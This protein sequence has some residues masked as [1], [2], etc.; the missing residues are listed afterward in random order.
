MNFQT[1]RTTFKDYPIFSKKEIEKTLSPFD[2]KNLVN[3]QK[4]NYVQKVRNEWY[5]L[6]ENHL[7]TPT[8]Y[9]IS[10]HIY[11]PSYISVESALAHYGFI[12]EGVFRHTAITTLKTQNFDTPIG[13]FTYQTLKPNLFFGYNLLNFNGFNYK[14]ADP[15][16]CILDFLYLNP[17]LKTEGHFYELRLNISD[18]KAQVDFDL[19]HKYAVAFDAQALMQRATAFVHFVE[20]S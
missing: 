13:L 17:H 15:Q 14:I 20:N 19:F 10:N 9:F 12:P 18:I 5:R 8:L 3:W 16:K 7:D 2:P 6:T 1:F 4:K 11:N